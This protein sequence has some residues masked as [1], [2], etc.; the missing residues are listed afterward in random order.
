[1]S[2]KDRLRK[3][4]ERQL[5]LKKKEEMAE[6]EYKENFT[7]SKSVNKYK[8]KKGQIAEAP[9]YLIIKLLMLIPY[10]WSAFFWGGVLSIAILGNMVNVYDFSELGKMTAVYIIVGAVIMAGALV[11]EFLKKYIAGFVVAFVGVMLYLKGVNQFIEP[12][13]K[14]LETKAVDEKLLGMDKTWMTR[15]YPIWAF[16]V[17]SG[18]L[19][20]ISLLEK[21]LRKRKERILRDNAPVKSIVSD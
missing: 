14:Y 20:G 15:C 8:K 16:L 12:I 18:V 3:E 6:R 17:L 21:Y 9:Y 13:T 11:F 5:A 4:K 2:K 7:E 10:G 19:L 1:M